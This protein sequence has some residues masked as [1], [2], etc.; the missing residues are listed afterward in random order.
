MKTIF[1]QK[2]TLPEAFEEAIVRTWREGS[3]FKTE[4]DHEGDLASKDVTAMIHIEDPFKEP[5]IHRGFPGSLEDLEIYRLEVVN[6]IHDYFMDD[7][8]NPERWKYTY[9]QRL[10]DYNVTEGSYAQNSTVGE[11]TYKPIE[12]KYNQI[13]ICIDKLKECS[14]T[15]RAQAVTWQVWNDAKIDDPP[16][17]QRLFF[18]ILDNKLHMNAHIRSNDSWKASFMN[19][20]GISEL[21]KFVADEI[22]I[23]TASLTWIADSYHIYGSYFNELE[24]FL[25]IVGQRDFEDRTY[26]TDMA[27]PFFIDGCDKILKESG[28]PDDKR[29]LVI[30]RK[31][32]LKNMMS[33]TL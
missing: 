22:G 32:D 16:C 7:K 20:W 23:E 15:R 21:Q 4:Y 19:L 6:G 12:K 26:T 18:R 11:R 24:G 30:K 9:S 28:L 17:L 25:K 29:E 10:F 33:N 27:I 13:Q 31:E 14:Y 8:S 3:E 2:E 1:V 5:R